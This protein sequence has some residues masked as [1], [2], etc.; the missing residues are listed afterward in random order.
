MISCQKDKFDLPADVTYLNTSYMA[1]QLKS[2]DEAGRNAVSKKLR[3][4]LISPEDFFEE[5]NAL[6]QAYAKLIEAPDYE[7]IAIIPSVS[8]G[9]A[10]VANNLDLKPNQKIIIVQDQF[11]T[12]V[13]TWLKL[14]E[15]TGATI[16]TIPAPD[17]ILNRGKLWNEAILAAIDDD[18]A[19]VSLPHVHWSEG[20]VFDLKAIRIKSRQHGALLAVDGTQSVGAYP[21]SIAEIQPDAL[22]C[23]GYKWLL[24][25]YSLGLAYYSEAFDGGNPIEE[26]WINRKNSEDFTR[27][28]D[29]EKAYKPKAHRYSVGE[30]SNFI[31]VPMLHTAINQLNAWG[32]ANIQAYCQEITAAFKEAVRALG[33]EF[34]NDDQ[35]AAHLF[36]IRIPDGI[37]I[38]Q[39][40]EAFKKQHIFVSFRGQNLRIASH[41]FNTKE[42]L[43]KVLA[44]LKEA[45]LLLK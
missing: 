30:S 25:A 27:L 43:A 40:K 9:M 6:K 20:I 3:P 38:D 5:S 35:I 17:D 44:C 45:S 37:S 16:Q 33:F 19:L 11:P 8:Y 39:L 1:A 7:R 31:L 22:I 12:N 21:F 42:D 32:V 18:T 10:T 15:R 26:N 13:Y 4:Y 23:G 41:L 14:A 28:V 29:Y 34:P 24:G 36:A 2:V